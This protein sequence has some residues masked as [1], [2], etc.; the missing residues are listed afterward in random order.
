MVQLKEF[1]HVDQFLLVLLQHLLILVLD[2]FFDHWSG[3]NVLEVLK[4]VE[5]VG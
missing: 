4:Q 3:V 5:C 2:L 1:V